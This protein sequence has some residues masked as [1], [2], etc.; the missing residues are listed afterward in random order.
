MRST[1]QHSSCAARCNTAHAQHVATQ[2]MRSTLQHSS[3]AARC[4]TARAQHVATQLVHSTLQHRPTRSRRTTRLCL[5][6]PCCGKCAPRC[7][8][9]ACRACPCSI[10]MR[11]TLPRQS[12]RPSTPSRNCT[13]PVH[14]NGS[15]FRTIKPGRRRIYTGCACVA[16]TCH[17]LRST[18]ACTTASRATWSGSCS[19]TRTGTAS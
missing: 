5:A 11:P 13:P 4:I 14:S 17:R 15:G 1:L 12:T 9:C 16:A 8:R 2:L 3:C 7:L 6:H 19:R 10:C 18:R